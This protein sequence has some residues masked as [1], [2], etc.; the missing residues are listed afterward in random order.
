M[1]VAAKMEATIRTEIASRLDRMG[2][3][4]VD[5]GDAARQQAAWIWVPGA[6]ATQ[7]AR[8]P[9]RRRALDVVV[10][11]FGLCPLER[12]PA[13]ACPALDAGWM[14]VRVKKARQNKEIEPPFRFNRN[15][16]GSSQFGDRDH[17]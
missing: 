17:G 1:A 11:D 15:G 3:S 13:K 10:F 16:K 5:H 4:S 7:P 6:P 2:I 14:P 12:F 9:R 8:N